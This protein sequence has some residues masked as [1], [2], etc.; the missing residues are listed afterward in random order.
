MTTP[1]VD[2]QSLHNPATGTAP[3]ASWG[4]AVRDGIDFAVNPPG[5]VVQGTV[6]GGVNN[7][8][9]SA[10]TNIAWNLADLRDTDNYHS[11]TT[12][13]ITIPTGLGGWYN[14]SGVV[15]FAANA[16]GVRMVRFQVNA[17]GENRLDARLAAGTLGTA[18]SFSAD[19]LLV[20]TDVLR[21]GAWQSS[22]AALALGT[23]TV[24][25]RLVAVS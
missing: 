2:P 8:T 4:D 17:A 22:G 14:I 20:P 23:S 1:Y 10:W 6:V 11:G 18:C 21:I 16:T 15:N 7:L 13:T 12:D 25:V 3:P 24:S 19:V 5:C 9:N